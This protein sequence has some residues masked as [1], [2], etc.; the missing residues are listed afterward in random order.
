MVSNLRGEFCWFGHGVFSWSIWNVS[1]DGSEVVIHALDAAKI[2]GHYAVFPS[3]S[4]ILCTSSPR[5]RRSSSVASMA[6]S[7]NGAGGI[8]WIQR[9]SPN[10][11]R[12]GA[13]TILPRA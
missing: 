3:R 4:Q 7:G 12:L 2:G 5:R 6:S 9:Y 11:L 8:E 10:A 1:V 13:T